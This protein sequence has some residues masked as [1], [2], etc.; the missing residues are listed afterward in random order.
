MKTN[1]LFESNSRKAQFSLINKLMMNFF[2]IKHL[3][4]N[5]RW[6]RVLEPLQLDRPLH[7][8]DDIS[9]PFKG[10]FIVD[11]TQYEGSQGCKVA[12]AK[13]CRM[14]NIAQDYKTIESGKTNTSW[15]GYVMPNI[16]SAPVPAPVPAISNGLDLLG[17]STSSEITVSSPPPRNNDRASGT[18]RA[19]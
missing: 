9:I 11:N 18:T 10:K 6:Y 1:F 17:V 12:R 8:Y 15:L 4:L 5:C 2:A 14:H 3:K 16:I 7:I 19:V 13:V